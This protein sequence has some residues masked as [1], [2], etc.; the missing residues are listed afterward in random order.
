MANHG[1]Q[2][3][4]YHPISPF[5]AT[6]PP[7][8]ETH[9]SNGDRRHYHPDDDTIGVGESQL[10]NFMRERVVDA[11]ERGISAGGRRGSWEP[12]D[13]MRGRR[14][15]ELSEVTLVQKSLRRRE[16]HEEKHRLSVRRSSVSLSAEGM[17]K[18]G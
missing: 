12:R 1:L 17:G 15:N 16:W 11:S 18:H 2:G 13:E 10:R 6:A 9:L 7:Y 4:S 5:R 3:I 8:P 14:A